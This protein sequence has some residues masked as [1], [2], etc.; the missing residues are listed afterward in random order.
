MPQLFIPITVSAAWAGA[1]VAVSQVWNSF[2]INT[3]LGL[4]TRAL[5][6][7]IEDDQGTWEPIA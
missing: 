7:R 5:S 6:G 3:V 2:V 4:A 1:A